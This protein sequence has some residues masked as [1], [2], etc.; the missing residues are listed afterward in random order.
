MKATH[1][2]QL[3]A[4]ALAAFLFTAC[5][6][7]QYTHV[8]PGKSASAALAE[9]N[10]APQTPADAATPGGMPVAANAPGHLPP[11][12]LPALPSG[13]VKIPGGTGEG[14]A[15]SYSRGT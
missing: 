7:V 5:S 15:D 4:A 13:E 1:P 8:A 2:F 14:V 12:A 6:G 3:P 11:E 10:R 9:R